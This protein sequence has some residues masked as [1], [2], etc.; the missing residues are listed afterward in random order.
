MST[1]II[2]NSSCCSD[3][4]CGCKTDVFP[5]DKK[6]PQCGKRLRLIGRAQLVEFRLSCNSCGYTGPLLSWKEISELL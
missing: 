2:Q 5:T 1:E 3:N 6:C 4:T